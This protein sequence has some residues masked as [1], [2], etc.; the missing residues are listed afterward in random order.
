MT[1]LH[2]NEWRVISYASRSLTDVERRYSQTE[3]EA[4]ALVWACERFNMYI[5]GHEFELETDHKPLECI[6]S[7]ISKP[8]ARIERWVLRLQAYDFKVVYRPGRCNIADALSRLN[9]SVQ[10]DK[11]SDYDFVR[12][13]VENSAPVAI[14]AKEIEKASVN[15]SELEHIKQCIKIGDWEHCMIPGYKHV[16]DELCVY[17]E[18]VLRGTRIVIPISLRKQVLQLAHEGHQGIVK[19]K[20]RLRTKVWWPKMDSD[21]EKLTK[22]CKG[23]QVV[24]QFT[25]PEPMARVLPPSGPWQDISADLLGPLPSKENILVVVDYYSRFYEVVVLKS[26]TSDKIISAMTKIFARFGVPHSLRTDN[27]P[28]FVS[29]EFS[30][31]LEEQGIEHRRTTPLWPQANGEVERQNRTL[32]KALRIAQV[33]GKDWHTEMFKFLTAYRSTPHTTT[34]RTP[35]YM[36]FGR[37]MKTKLPELRGAL[38]VCDE[39]TRE[40]DWDK[41]LQGKE[42]SD[43]KRNAVVNEDLKVGDRVLVKNQK[44][45]K[46]SPNFMLNPCKVVK[47]EK[48]EITLENDEGVNYKRN[49]TFVKKFIEPPSEPPDSPDESRPS[50]EIKMPKRFEDF[51]MK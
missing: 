13:V 50:R 51:V 5:F 26:T 49:V 6:Y 23:C 19:T 45:D 37:E 33:E 8:S 29:T 11:G 38:G 4:L 32:M 16:K 21:A 1:Q 40:R 44:N 12:S 22:T 48:G 30:N 41:K 18:I 36:M 3:K 27:G 17:G 47:R 24:G 39:E 20:M 46:M 7:R 14:T 43:K 25:P 31:F 34:G 10:R 15:D 35:F 2:D 28:Q 9:A 42:Y